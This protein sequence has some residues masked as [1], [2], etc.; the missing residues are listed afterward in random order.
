VRKASNLTVICEP[1]VWKLWVPQSDKS[2]TEMA[3]SSYL[4]LKRS[5]ELW[6]SPFLYVSGCTNQY[7]SVYVRDR[8][9]L[10]RVHYYIARG[11]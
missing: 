11:V 3:L 7:R 9:H 8:W 6:L 10:D 5:H 2:E 1:T 4:L